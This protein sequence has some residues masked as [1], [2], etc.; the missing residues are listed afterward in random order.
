MK[1]AQIGN[2]DPPHSTENELRKALM[3]NSC[4]V[5]TY[6]EGDVEAWER[7]R[8]EITRADF[9]VWT[10]TA[11]ELN[12][13]PVNLQ[14]QVVG[15]ARDAG[16]PVVGYHLD[17][18]WGLKRELEMT[19]VPYF[20]LV[21]YMCTADGGHDEKFAE[22]GINHRWFPP[23]VSEFECIPGNVRPEYAA[24]LGFVGC[25]DGSYH[26]EWK[27]RKD[28]VA[29]LKNRGARFWPEKGKEAVRG[30]DLRDLY[31][32]VDVVVGDSCLVGDHGY[33][34]SDRIPETLGRA[35][36]LI[37]PEVAGLEEHFTSGVHLETW[38]L[39]N[40][41]MLDRKI[42]ELWDDAERRE[43]LRLH[44]REHV[45]RN[46]TYTVRMRQLIDMLETDGR[47]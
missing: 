40:W 19:S 11:S 5:D 36:V 14:K 13:I 32:S 20:T 47:L 45:L 38:K 34:W 35:G 27:H 6:Q 30:S 4:A 9:V 17:I 24:S 41:E 29:H 21:D 25:W 7:L 33:Y 28:L 44:G 39:F 46:H 42:A 23:G 43:A 8:G 3:A 31:A 15:K 18:W 26:R 2:F 10:R 22:A 12:K 37:H 16:V 1:V